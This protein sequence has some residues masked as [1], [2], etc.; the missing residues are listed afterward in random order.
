MGAAARGDFGRAGGVP[1]IG[2]DFLSTAAEMGIG[3]AGEVVTAVAGA[4]LATTALAEGA[5][6]FTDSLNEFEPERGAG[7]WPFPFFLPILLPVNC[8][9]KEYFTI[10]ISHA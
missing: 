3:I 2:D 10:Y 6:V 1:T 4:T 8:K 7:P 5:V 9:L